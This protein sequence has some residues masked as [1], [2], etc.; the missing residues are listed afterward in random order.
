[1]FTKN[2]KRNRAIKII[3]IGLGLTAMV[4]IV[5]S[6]ITAKI[7]YDSQFPRY[8]RPDETITAQQRYSDIERDYPR[9]PVTFKSGKNALQGYIYGGD[10]SRG[11]LVIAHGIGG[12]ADSYLPQIQHFVD[13]DL[14]V[15][16]YD[17]TG[18]YDSEGMST[19]GFPQ[20]V[21]D[22]HAALTFIAGQPDLSDL[23]L[24]L[25]GHSW[26]G[27]AVVN[28][29]HYP[30]D[31][32]GVIS[33]S[34]VNNALDII[35]EQGRELMGGFIYTQYPFLWL[36]QRLLFGE[37][38]SFDAVSAI[39]ATDIPTLIIHGEADEMVSYEGSALIASRNVIENPNASYV[40]ASTSGRNGHTNLFRTDAAIAYIK[41]VNAAY[42]VVYD[43]YDGQI[44][45]TVKKNFYDGIDRIMLRELEPGLMQ[46]IDEFIDGVLPR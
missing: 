19:R 40:K 39:N 30:H 12:G 23:P 44:P 26:G 34:G 8:D 17:C 25:F 2:K 18:S 37:V 9:I 45:Y 32:Q 5:V 28:V 35:L 41:E 10:N 33:I 21:V 31:V 3:V 14:R 29:L 13:N 4:F 38:A 22:L 15:F 20:S 43:S 24:V 11:L 46:V 6:L 16:A 27:Y 7:V 36:Y 42:R 1:M